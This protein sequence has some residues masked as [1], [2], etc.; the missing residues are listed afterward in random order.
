MFEHTKVDKVELVANC[1]RLV[2]PK[3]DKSV[4]FHKKA[5]EPRNPIGFKNQQSLSC[6][7]IFKHLILIK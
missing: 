3:K 6:H 2:I 5:S 4:V 7:P 1:N